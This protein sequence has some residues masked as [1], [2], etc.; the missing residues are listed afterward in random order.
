MPHGNLTTF[1]N[2]QIT[3]LRREMVPI[4]MLWFKIKR[5]KTGVENFTHYPQ[6]SKMLNS[7]RNVKNI[8]T[9]E[10]R[11]LVREACVATNHPHHCADTCNY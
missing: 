7:T 1:E 5:S 8:S 11:R 6:R 4:R 2:G 10:E 3:A 9:S